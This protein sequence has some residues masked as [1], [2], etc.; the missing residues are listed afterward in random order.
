MGWAPVDPDILISRLCSS[1]VNHGPAT[2][3]VVRANIC[4]P[5]V[6]LNVTNLDFGE[7]Y[8]GQG[9]SMTV[10]I[11]NGT[12]VMAE[13]EFLKVKNEVRREKRRRR[14]RVGA[15]LASLLVSTQPGPTSSN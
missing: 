12:P 8:V 15:T 3:I 9:K 14:K 11:H 2:L 7:V 6:S 4:V 5:D 13:W 1:T 10:Q